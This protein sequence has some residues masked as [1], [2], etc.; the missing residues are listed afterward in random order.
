M[1]KACSCCCAC[2][3][4][5]VKVCWWFAIVLIFIRSST[6]CCICCH[7]YC[8]SLSNC[9]CA[10]CWIICKCCWRRSINL[11]IK[12]LCSCFTLSVSN[13]NCIL[14]SN[15][16]CRLMAKAC[17][18]CCAC[19]RCIFWAALWLAIISILIR[20][21]TTCCICCHCYCLTL[22]DCCCTD[23]W[24][25]CKLLSYYFFN[26]NSLVIWSCISSGILSCY[27]NC[28][29]SSLWW[30]PCAGLSW[31]I[32]LNYFIISWELICNRT[33]FA[34]AACTKSNWIA[35]VDRRCWA[36]KTYFKLSSRSF[37]EVNKITVYKELLLCC[38]H[39]KTWL[40]C[41]WKLCAWTIAENN[42]NC[43]TEF[44]RKLICPVIA[45]NLCH[46]SAWP[47]TIVAVLCVINISIN[48][49]PTVACIIKCYASL[50]KLWIACSWCFLFKDK[51]FFFTCSVISSCLNSN[52]NSLTWCN[53]RTYCNCLAAC[54][55]T[56]IAFTCFVSSR[57]SILYL[58]NNIN[59]ICRKCCWTVLCICWNFNNCW[60][61]WRWVSILLCRIIYNSNTVL[62]SN[63]TRNFTTRNSKLIAR[64]LVCISAVF[65]IYAKAYIACAVHL[66]DD[67]TAVASY[68]IST[69]AWRTKLF[70]LTYE[71]IMES[72]D[73]DNF[74]ISPSQCTYITYLSLVSLSQNFFIS[75]SWLITWSVIFKN[76]LWIIWTSKEKCCW[77]L[78][79][80]NH[81]PSLFNIAVIYIIG[82][83]STHICIVRFCPKNSL[84]ALTCNIT[85]VTALCSTACRLILYA[86]SDIVTCRVVC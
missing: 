53:R 41:T 17:S 45:V 56:L 42:I 59:R 39:F 52:S 75:L 22:S 62:A 66:R 38:S 73:L 12:V 46:C 64:N 72:V 67:N 19:K 21:S 7:C 29:N 74:L 2:K 34:C 55:R 16:S 28:I 54:E 33:I 43:S 71:E 78:S 82:G 36:W 5:P 9:C 58:H 50:A 37:R 61:Y 81:S 63:C 69:L 30:F 84:V 6:A 32:S 77:I 80:S 14:I 35:E 51:C 40:V 25:I 15:C 8:L 1:A 18:C 65:H 3:C 70:T 26:C 10:D 49:R 23:C 83:T 4:S 24:I 13:L 47:C 27:I 48:I 44:I 20:S 86:V 79:W 31:T 11:Y 68:T 76:I 57:C 60:F 85:A